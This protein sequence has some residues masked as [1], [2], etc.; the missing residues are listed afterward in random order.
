MTVK[1]AARRK[2]GW[3]GYARV[4]FAVCDAPQTARQLAAA[5][6]VS[7]PT[8]SRVLNRMRAL[9][10]AHRCDYVSEGPRCKPVAVWRGGAG[11]EPPTPPWVRERAPTRANALPEVVAACILLRLLQHPITR[12]ELALHSGASSTNVRAFLRAL[13]GLG[14]VRIAA[15]ACDKPGRPAAMFELGG[16]RSERPPAAKTRSQVNREYRLGAIARERQR[17]ILQ[18][19]VRPRGAQATGAPA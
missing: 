10:F 8:V 2:L 15:W 5:L 14:R 12:A 16:G 18:A 4:Y 3:A 7:V 1:R 9:G 13:R 11:T 6:N 19:L 17:Q